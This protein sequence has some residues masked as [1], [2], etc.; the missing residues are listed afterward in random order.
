ML[1]IYLLGFVSVRLMY[2]NLLGFCKT[3]KGVPQVSIVAHSRGT[4]SMIKQQWGVVYPIYSLNF[5]HN[6]SKK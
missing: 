6:S 4:L 3:Q 2:Q 5:L 1:Y